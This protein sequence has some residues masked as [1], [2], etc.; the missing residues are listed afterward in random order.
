[1]KHKIKLITG[2]RTD[3]HSTVDADEAHKAYY[4][5]RNPEERGVFNNGVAIVGK[6]IKGIE[7]D[8][9][10]TMG[11]NPTHQ[12]DSNDYN[13]LRGRGVDVEIRDALANGKLLA[14]QITSSNKAEILN[15]PLKKALEIAAGKG[16]PALN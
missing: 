13:E 3:Q 11:W 9:H 4:L 12:L 5:F 14:D 16:L 1:M 15:A 8:Y 10:A 7:P 6:Y 2:F